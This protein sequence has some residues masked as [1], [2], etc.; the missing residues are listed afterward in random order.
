MDTPHDARPS[1]AAHTPIS[2][3]VPASLCAHASPQD[4]LEGDGQQQQQDEARDKVGWVHIHLPV[5]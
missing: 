1:Y 2:S 4:A 5:V 3:Q